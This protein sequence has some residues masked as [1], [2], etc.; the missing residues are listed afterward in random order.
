MGT[1]TAKSKESKFNHKEY[2]SRK[3]VIK[4]KVINI[5]EKPKK[6]IKTV[7]TRASPETARLQ[8]IYENLGD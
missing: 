3:T 1:V 5:S 4:S 6:A 2:K 8:I 7:K